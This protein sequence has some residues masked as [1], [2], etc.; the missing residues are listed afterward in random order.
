MLDSV[1]KEKTMDP[2]KIYEQSLESEE[3]ERYLNGLSSDEERQEFFVRSSIMARNKKEHLEAKGRK[4]WSAEDQNQNRNVNANENLLYDFAHDFCGG[5][6]TN[7]DINTFGQRLKIAYKIQYKAA[8][9]LGRKQK[10]IE[11]ELLEHDPLEEHAFEKAA[12]YASNTPE[13]QY[14]VGTSDYI[15]GQYELTNIGKIYEKVTGK[16]WEIFQSECNKAALDELKENLSDVDRKNLDVGMDLAS[17]EPEI[18]RN[19][20][21]QDFGLNKRDLN[22][23]NKDAAVELYDRLYEPDNQ[24][25]IETALGKFNTQRS[26]V[27]GRNDDGT[28]KETKEH[29]ELREATKKLLDM[30]KDFDLKKG[31]W[32]KEEYRIKLNSLGAQAKKVGELADDYIG[33]RDGFLK[34]FAGRDRLNGAK[35]IKKEAGKI[36]DW[37]KTSLD[38]QKVRD[39]EK[40]KNISFDFTDKAENAKKGNNKADDEEIKAGGGE[41]IATNEKELKEKLG[42]NKD[43]NTENVRKSQVN[44]IQNEEVKGKEVQKGVKPMHLN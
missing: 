5:D 17:R 42:I 35:D 29:K 37:V 11:N 33:K 7:L 16:K 25:D 19:H 23:L 8:L 9:E 6:G 36:T 1:R 13:Y 39:E 27:F 44:G 28:S 2:R 3:V 31:G 32:N 10:K 4:N 12:Y 26:R 18:F 20:K 21:P 22:E 34:T 38:N 14:A 24:K 41:V 43:K 15:F 40:R 30:K